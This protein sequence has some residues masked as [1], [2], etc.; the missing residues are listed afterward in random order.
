MKMLIIWVHIKVEMG[1][2]VACPLSYTM[3]KC[4]Q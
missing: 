4:L 3:L 1:E 2:S